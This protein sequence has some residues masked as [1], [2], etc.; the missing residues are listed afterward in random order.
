[1]FFWN[2]DARIRHGYFNTFRH[3][4]GYFALILIEESYSVH[5]LSAFVTRF[6]ITREMLSS[7]YGST[8]IS[9]SF[10]PQMSHPFFR[11]HFKARQSS[12][13]RLHNVAFGFFISCVRFKLWKIQNI[14]H[15]IIQ[16]D[17]F[18]IYEHR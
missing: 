4:I 6:E 14:I 10:Q 9:P 18:L 8:G 13:K 17:N 7:L 5:I 1:M 12:F 3:F 2:T 16:T 11:K 15:H